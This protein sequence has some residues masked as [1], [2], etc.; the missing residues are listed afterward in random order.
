MFTKFTEATYDQQLF[1][2]TLHP[3]TSVWLSHSLPKATQMAAEGKT[4]DYVSISKPRT[5]IR[6]WLN[7]AAAL[8]W[9]AFCYGLATNLGYVIEDFVIGDIN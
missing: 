1:D 7:E 8:E 5:Y 4:D 3:E 6:V 2:E 9:K